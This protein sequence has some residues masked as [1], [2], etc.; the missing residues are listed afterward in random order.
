MNT[1]DSLSQS[2]NNFVLISDFNV[3][4]EEITVSIFLNAYNLK[5]VV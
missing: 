5:N 4:I 2:Y 1:L 3:K